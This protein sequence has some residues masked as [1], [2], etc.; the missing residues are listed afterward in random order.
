MASF[1]V[2]IP[3]YVHFTIGTPEMQF[4]EAVEWIP[5]FNVNYLLGVDGISLLLVLLNSFVTV[6]V[7]WAGWEVI[8]KKVAQYMA[9]FLIMSGL[10]NGVFVALDG[11][12]FY[13]F[14][15]VDADS[16]V[17][18]HRRLGRAESRL[19]R[20]QVLPLHAAR[21]AADAGRADLSVFGQRRRASR[22][23]SGISCRCR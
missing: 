17:P 13:V 22:F 18:D 1:A 12:L 2:T 10:T 14:F 16:A 19:R 8:E 11:V 23:W 21:F 15:E 4:V 9:A 20:D 6:L 3:L 5:R 7:V